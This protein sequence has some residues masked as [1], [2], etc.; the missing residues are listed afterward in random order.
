MQIRATGINYDKKIWGV[1]TVLNNSIWTLKV[2]TK[3]CPKD[4]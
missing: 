4:K 3:A 1:P 2:D